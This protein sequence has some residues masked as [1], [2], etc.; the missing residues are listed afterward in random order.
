VTEETNI[1]LL[2]KAIN[3]TEKLNGEESNKHPDALHAYIHLFGK[4]KYDEIKNSKRYAIYN[5]FY[6]PSW[7]FEKEIEKH[8]IPSNKVKGYIGRIKHHHRKNMMLIYLIKLSLIRGELNLALDYIDDLS[9]EKF[10]SKFHGYRQI[11]QYYAENP[12]LKEF[13]KY[14][15]LSK[16]GKS[17]RN[18]I[19][20]SKSKFISN[21]SKINGIEEGIELLNSNIFGW[22]FCYSVIENTADK[23]S[24]KKNS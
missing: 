4:E 13:K 5:K 10:E 8:N 3:S 24:I 23:F 21:Y 15:K 14:L 11:L 17:P 19:S 22:K 2:I 12:N 6:S 1:E 20:I 18:V 7:C 16:P 9:E